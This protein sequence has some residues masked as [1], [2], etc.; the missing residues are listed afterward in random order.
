MQNKKAIKTKDKRTP[1]KIV[2]RMQEDNKGQV[3]ECVLYLWGEKS[4]ILKLAHRAS[5]AKGFI[6]SLSKIRSK[7]FK[8][9]MLQL[10]YKF[11][12]KWGDFHRKYEKIGGKQLCGYHPQ[13]QKNNCEGIR[14][15]RAIIRPL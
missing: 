8:T 11:R 9:T 1:K 5:L 4:S 10:Q 14:L 7:S 6:G 15:V 3:W 13:G 12:G 2:G